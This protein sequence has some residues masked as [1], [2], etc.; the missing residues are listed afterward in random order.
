M[1]PPDPAAI[2]RPVPQGFALTTAGPDTIFIHHRRTGMGCLNA[3]LLAWLMAW[4]AGCLL[5]F[6]VHPDKARW[7]NC[8]PPPAWAAALFWGADALVA[9]FTAYLF[10]CRK[11]FRIDRDQLV[12]ETR[13]LGLR[14]TRTLA[15]ADLRRFVQFKDGGEGEDSFPSWALRTEGERKTTLL[16]RQPYECSQ[17]LGQTLARWA[18]GEYVPAPPP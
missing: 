16:V 9:F 10:F 3:F 4:T 18:G 6:V 2:P 5:F 14:W 13:L 17:W 8:S 15:R 7:V 12:I 1:P 11:S